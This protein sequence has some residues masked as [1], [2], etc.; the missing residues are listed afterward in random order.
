MFQRLKLAGYGV[1]MVQKQPAPAFLCTTFIIDEHRAIQYVFP[2]VN[3]Q[4]HIYAVLR[5]L[6]G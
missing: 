2:N 4:I 3:V 5:I 6:E 1:K